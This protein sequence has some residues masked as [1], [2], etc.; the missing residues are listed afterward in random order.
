MAV[1][2]AASAVLEAIV[3]T[4]ILERTV[5]ISLSRAV[6]RGLVLGLKITQVLTRRH[7]MG[8]RQKISKSPGPL[9]FITSVL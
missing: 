8:L 4:V 7:W 9:T 5:T 6:K 2:P 1:K 3:L